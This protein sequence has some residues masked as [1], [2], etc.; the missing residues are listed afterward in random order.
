MVYE[1]EVDSRC[2]GTRDYVA[3]AREESEECRV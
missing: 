3:R 1:A 2:A